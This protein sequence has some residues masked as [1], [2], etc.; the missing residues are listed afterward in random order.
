ML[1]C[2]SRHLG[3]P[4]LVPCR[5]R[6]SA[7]AFR[8]GARPMS[9]SVS[10]PGSHALSGGSPRRSPAFHLFGNILG[11]RPAQQDGGQTAPLPRMGRAQRRAGACEPIHRTAYQPSSP[12]RPQPMSLPVSRLVSG[13]VCPRLA[14][15]RVLLPCLTR[16]ALSRVLSPF[17]GAMSWQ[18]PWARRS[19]PHVRSRVVGWSSGP[20]LGPR[21][22]PARPVRVP[23]PL[24]GAPCAFLREALSAPLLGPV[25][26]A[27]RTAPNQEAPTQSPPRTASQ[28]P[29]T[30]AQPP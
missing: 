1:R 13:P 17:L 24:F 7:A 30:R 11:G 12:P 28:A 27:P 21:S 8:P 20:L 3:S 19:G 16:F 5:A 14:R 22:S 23:R 29:P 6:V 9:H 15:H 26:E 10:G 4:C 25:V 18:P 2:P